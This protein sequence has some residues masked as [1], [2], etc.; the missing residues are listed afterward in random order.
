MQNCRAAGSRPH[1][2]AS[3][4]SLPGRWPATDST[5]IH[6]VQ[7]RL[8]HC[9]Y[10]GPFGVADFGEIN[11]FRLATGAGSNLTRPPVSPDPAP[12]EQPKVNRTR[13]MTIPAFTRAHSELLTSERLIASA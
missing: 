2:N 4:R 5:E 3:R 13:N 10:T 12:N 6:C 1:Q 9:G 8:E 11:C 7:Y